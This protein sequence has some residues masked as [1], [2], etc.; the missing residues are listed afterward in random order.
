MRR[1]LDTGNLINDQLNTLSSTIEP[2]K[3]IG[4]KFGTTDLETA[5]K[6]Y[7][8]LGNN[9][10]SLVKEIIKKIQL[11]MVSEKQE[12]QQRKL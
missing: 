10:T 8:V 4:P 6:K 9:T 2:K 3:N 7:R 5:M 12:K 1:C 11:Q